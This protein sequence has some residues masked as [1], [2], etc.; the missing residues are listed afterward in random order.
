[1]VKDVWNLIFLSHQ[2]TTNW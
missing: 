1:M 2:A